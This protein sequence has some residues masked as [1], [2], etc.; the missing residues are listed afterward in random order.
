[1]STLHLVVV[2]A[3]VAANTAVVV[4]DL[5]R[6]P[7]VLTNSSEVGVP[8]SWLPLLAVLKAA[9][10]AGLVIGTA[11]LPPLAVAAAGGLVAFFL[12]AVAATSEHARSTT[13]P[14]PARTSRWPPPRSHS[15]SP[16][17]AGEPPAPRVV[18]TASR[19]DP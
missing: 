15:L 9:G 2:A 6:A 10:C 7:F 18:P 3:T 4:A 13:S 1:M 19:D 8:P 17:P 14:S 12:G 5:V 16:K 11:A